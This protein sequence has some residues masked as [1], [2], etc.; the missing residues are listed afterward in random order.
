MSLLSKLFR[1][2]SDTNVK[3]ARDSPRESPSASPR[4]SPR[5]S[6][7]APPKR[8]FMRVVRDDNAAGE[9]YVNPHVVRKYNYGF[10]EK[11]HMLKKSHSLEERD[12]PLPYTVTGHTILKKHNS[13][14]ENQPT[15]SSPPGEK[16]HAKFKEVVE[17]VEYCPKTRCKLIL[18]DSCILREKLHDEW[19][20]CLDVE[21]QVPREECENSHDDEESCKAILDLVLDTVS[22]SAPLDSISEDD[23]NGT[24]EDPTLSDCSTPTD[25]AAKSDLAQAKC[26]ECQSTQSS[27]ERTEIQM[28]EEVSS[29]KSRDGEVHTPE[30]QCSSDSDI[31]VAKKSKLEESSK[32]AQTP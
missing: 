26:T 4:T 28:D 1:S 21:F 22:R 19:E 20:E 31:I 10:W 24:E 17:V 14:D 3:T 25:E 15:S 5:G 8:R 29:D 9:E 7:G 18:E 12:R 6:P 2:K 30:R 16:K 32:S 11:Q 13:M 23:Y 27:A